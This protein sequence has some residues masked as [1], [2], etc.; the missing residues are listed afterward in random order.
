MAMGKYA[1]L[2]QS[3]FFSII[4]YTEMDIIHCN[5]FIKKNKR[6][7]YKKGKLHYDKY[8]V[9]IVITRSLIFPNIKCQSFLKWYIYVNVIHQNGNEFLFL[10]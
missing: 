10:L 8:Y 7:L 2:I 1:F 9:K 6:L 5:N 4:S 3:F